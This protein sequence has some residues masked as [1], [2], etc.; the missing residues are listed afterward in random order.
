M[1]WPYLIR[2]SFPGVPN[3]GCYFGT[4]ISVPADNQETEPELGIFERRELNQVHGTN[5]FFEPGE[6][7][8]LPEADGQASSAPGQ[9]LLIRTADCQPIMVADKSGKYILALHCGWRGN[10][11]GFP[12]TGIKRFCAFYRL[13][14]EDILAVR[15]PSLGPGCSE[16]RDFERHWPQS[17]LGYLNLENSCLDLWSLTRDQLLTAGMRREN[18]FSLDLCTH[19][20]SEAF[21]SYRRSKD[22]G[23]MENVI[24]I[25]G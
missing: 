17:M 15:G 19:C 4:K 25:R 3:I 23:R 2:F 9:A 10:R 18:I 6:A 16:F 14:P 11:A 8:P 7:D 24:W 1:A 21:F 12:A 20:L 22:Q 5:I 13:D